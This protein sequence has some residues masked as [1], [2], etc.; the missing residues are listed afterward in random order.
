MSEQNEINQI[1][2]M[3]DNLNGKLDKMSKNIE[4][5][6]ISLVN[7]TQ[8]INDSMINVSDNLG[9]LI[10]VF[11][12]TFKFSDLSNSNK[13]I[14]SIAEKMNDKFDVNSFQNTIGEVHT[15]IKT[16]KQLQ[17]GDGEK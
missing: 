15:L 6:A 7:L 2:A 14:A 1:S 3:F 10:N 11:E 13:I 16:L 8:Q 9:G 12:K 17:D 4:N 5:I